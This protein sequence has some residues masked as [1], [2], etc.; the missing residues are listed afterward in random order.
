MAGD[1]RDEQSVSESL[2]RELDQIDGIGTTTIGNFAGADLNSIEDV[3]RLTPPEIENRVDGIGSTKAQ[4][5]FERLESEGYTEYQSVE[6]DVEFTAVDEEFATHVRPLL[7]EANDTAQSTRP[8]NVGQVSDMFDRDEFQSIEQWRE[9][10]LNSNHERDELKDPLS[11]KTGED[12]IEEATDSTWEKI[13]EY[14]RVLEEIER[15]TVKRWIE[16]LV[17]I[18]TPEGLTHEG[19]VLEHLADEY[20]MELTDSSADEESQ[21]IDGYLGEKPVSVKSAEYATNSRRE[22]IEDIDHP[23]ILYSVGQNRD[24]QGDTETILYLYYDEDKLSLAE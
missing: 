7:N 12:L 6:V 5:V 23:I 20:D 9:W 8:E 14:R 3:A 10:Y 21:G 4:R 15:E 16:E 18:K 1:G 2:R 22:E 17:L 13:Q 19:E 11:G 24:D